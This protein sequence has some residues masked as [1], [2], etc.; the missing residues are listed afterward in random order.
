MSAAGDRAISGAARCFIC[1][2]DES[3]HHE[4]QVREPGCVCDG[5]SWAPN[6]ADPV[7]RAYKGDGLEYCT[8]CQHDKD[9][10]KSEDSQ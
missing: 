8:V 3:D 4:F 5:A 10:H 1:G 6:N 2:S 9:C 7:C